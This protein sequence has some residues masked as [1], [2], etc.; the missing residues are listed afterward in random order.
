MSHFIDSEVT[1]NCVLLNI[2]HIK[3]EQDCNVSYCEGWQWTD[4]QLTKLIMFKMNGFDAAVSNIGLKH[5][6]L[7][8]FSVW[9]VTS[10]KKH[11]EHLYIYRGNP[12]LLCMQS[13]FIVTVH[14][15]NALDFT[16]HSGTLSICNEWDLIWNH[17]DL[18]VVCLGS[19]LASKHTFREGHNS[20]MKYKK[21]N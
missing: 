7:L 17:A 3:K 11:N 6:L 13:T 4:I 1:G 5:N 10:G 15:C 12:Q 18:C 20:S 14:C 2:N 9:L 16:T 8:K 19:R 21:S